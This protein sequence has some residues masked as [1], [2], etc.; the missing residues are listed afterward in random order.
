MHFSAPHK[1]TCTFASEFKHSIDELE[2]VKFWQE[3][4]KKMDQ[5]SAFD[6][7]YYAFYFDLERS[8]PITIRKCQVAYYNVIYKYIIWV[9]ASCH[10]NWWDEM[11]ISNNDF[12][13]VK[14][15]TINHPIR[16]TD[17]KKTFTSWTLSQDLKKNDQFLWEIYLTV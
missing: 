4:E 9:T 12:S 3:K 8:L 5:K 17:S 14:P 11:K 13:S 16:M 6:S 2:V 1:D 15:V 10:Q 7:S